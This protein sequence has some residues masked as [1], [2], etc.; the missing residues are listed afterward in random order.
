MTRCIFSTDFWVINSH[1]VISRFI[2]CIHKYTPILQILT[3]IDTI[4]SCH[5]CTNI[6]YV[7][8]VRITYY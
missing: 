1:D 5:P 7:I 4:N 3:S 6:M 2:Y 8:L